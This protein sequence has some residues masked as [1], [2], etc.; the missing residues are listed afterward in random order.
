MNRRG[1]Q[2]L[3]EIQ[4]SPSAVGHVR[5]DLFP[6][7]LRAPFSTTKRTHVHESHRCARN[8]DKMFRGRIKK[9][10][11]KWPTGWSVRLECALYC[12]REESN[13]KA[14]SCNSV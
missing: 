3:R 4:E 11:M 8:L 13:G 12:E 9:K 6:F 2:W 5:H 10:E 14:T 1:D 7:R